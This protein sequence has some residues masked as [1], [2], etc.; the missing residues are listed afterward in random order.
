MGIRELSRNIGSWVAPEDAKE[1]KDDQTV[2][3]AS[4]FDGPRT[5]ANN[6]EQVMSP[7]EPNFLE[8]RCGSLEPNHLENTMQVATIL[9]KISFREKS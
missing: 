9:W 3:R 8:R 7:G 4:G 6:N 5:R 2:R 1:P